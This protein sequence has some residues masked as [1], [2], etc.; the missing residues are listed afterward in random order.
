MTK[1]LDL[2]RFTTLS[3]SCS[4]DQ[5][6]VS[7]AAVRLFDQKQIFEANEFATSGA[8]K[9]RTFRHRDCRDDSVCWQ[10][11]DAGDVVLFY[12]KFG[13][14]SEAPTQPRAVMKALGVRLW[15]TD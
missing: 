5:D 8:M 14:V 1:P 6:F 7:V 4:R 15:S 3:S 9:S 2:S 10:F 12:M 13:G 11:E